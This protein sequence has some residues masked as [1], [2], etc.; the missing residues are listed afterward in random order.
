MRILVLGGYG[1]IGEA[2]TRRL[3]A[4]GYQVV[5]LG[6]DIAK[7]APRLPAAE[8]MAADIARLDAPARWLPILEAARPG[9]I[10]N[11]AG[12][13]QDGVR[14]DLR[15][16]QSAAMRALYLAAEAS[17]IRQFV[18]ISAPRADTAS[19]TL[20]MRT[21]GEADAALM[22]SP[23]EWTVLRPGL[24]L[25]PEAYGGTALLRALAGV[26]FVLPLVHSDRPIQTVALA[27]VAA[28][29]AAVIARQV[30][31]HRV[32]DLV[33][34]EAHT[35]AA[36]A[37]SV[38]AWLGRPPAREVK[39]PAVAVGL[40]A[41]LGDVLGWLG[42]RPPLRTTALSEIASGIVGDPGPWRHAS[43]RAL[44]GLQATLALLP[45]TVQERWF[46]RLYLLKPIVITTLAVF[47]VATG[48]IALATQPAA[49]G[50][51]TA[52][53]LGSGPAIVI[54]TAGSL[55]DI[56]LGLAILW[57]RLM[58]WAAGGMIALS[59]AYLAGGTLLAP[60]LWADPL[61]PL[62]KAVPALVLALVALAVAEER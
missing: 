25:G 20:F 8:W 13:L 9:A 33:E 28:A 44:T 24:V 5:G 18:Q 39:V 12:A 47:W 61:G 54:V 32:Y 22:A 3:L 35:F 11:C 7:A 48:L 29:V 15:R 37:R 41:R 51:L 21:K 16:L 45:S 4:D 46:A 34:D 19:E 31:A 40:A 52:R 27:E 2:V 30:P 59:L 1:L 62:V 56:G 43:G 42:W 49:A 14:D 58:P 23:L 17:G 6:R 53:G 26:P 50:L 57:R 55:L 38:R 10:V 60:D 36:V